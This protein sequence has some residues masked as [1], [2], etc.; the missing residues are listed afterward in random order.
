MSWVLDF[1]DSRFSDRLVLLAIA[2]HCDRYG[3]EAW[4]M[5]STLAAEARVSTREVIRAIQS[6]VAMG[7]LQVQKGKGKIGRNLYSLP[8][9]EGTSSQ[10]ELRDKL[11]LREDDQVTSM[12]LLSDKSVV[13][14][15]QITQ[16]NKEEPSLTVLNQPVLRAIPFPANFQPNQRNRE[17]AT[18]LEIDLAEALEAFSDYHQSKGSRFVN[19]HMALNTWLRNDRRFRPPK[20]IPGSLFPVRDFAAERQEKQIA[21]YRRKSAELEAKRVQSHAN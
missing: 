8:L 14:M 3:R 1:S 6:L 11:S 15:C 7:E 2:N 21:E 13:P 20:T 12:P 9:M 5:H 18:A 10:T 17:N 19:W 16:R 4:P